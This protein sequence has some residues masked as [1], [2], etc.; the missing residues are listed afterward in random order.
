MSDGTLLF[1]HGHA[2]AQRDRVAGELLPLRRR[3]RHQVPGLRLQ[4]RVRLPL[5]GQ[6]RR[7]RAAADQQHVRLGLRFLAGILRASKDAG[8]LP[9]QLSRVGPVRDRRRR[10]HRRALVP[11]PHAPG[12]VQRRS[13]RDQELPLHERRSTSTARGR[14]ACSFP[15]SSSSDSE[16]DSDRLVAEEAGSPDAGVP[17]AGLA[18]PDAASPSSPPADLASATAAPDQPVP[19]AARRVVVGGSHRH[20]LSRRR[21][22][23]HGGLPP[24]PNPRSKQGRSN[25]SSSARRDDAIQSDRAPHHGRARCPALL[26]G[27]A[28]RRRCRHCASPRRSAGTRGAPA[29]ARPPGR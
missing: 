22:D 25:V 2:G 1:A 7:R 9:P 17:D 16:S 23:V 15:R 18:P 8:T 21:P 13:D 27:A 5:A 28:G 26:P 19:R 11:L 12:L 14:Q 6:V 20:R 4:R 29:L 10:R 24:S 3:R